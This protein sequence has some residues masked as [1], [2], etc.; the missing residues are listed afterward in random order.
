MDSNEK[1]FSRLNRRK[2]KKLSKHTINENF[3]K[4]VN[5]DKMKIL[6]EKRKMEAMKTIQILL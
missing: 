6:K 1:S 2:G 3:K 4:R 5:F